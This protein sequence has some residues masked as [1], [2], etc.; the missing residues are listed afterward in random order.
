[1]IVS[2]VYNDSICALK[3][4]RKDDRQVLSSLYSIFKNKMIELRVNTLSDE[5]SLKLIQKFIKT[6][7]DEILAFTQAKRDDKVIILNKQKTLILKYLPKMLSEDEI[8]NEILNLPDR[9]IPNVMK[10]FK[11]NF[12]GKVDMKLVNTILKT[13]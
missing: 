4:G 6:L 13:L 2:K 11:T 5:E 12:A 9:T 10:H 1:M 7:D 8:K 3:E